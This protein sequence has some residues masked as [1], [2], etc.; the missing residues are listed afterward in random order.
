M[1]TRDTRVIGNP[2]IAGGG[3]RLGAPGDVAQA[4]PTEAMI[5]HQFGFDQGYADGL[6]QAGAACEARWKEIQARWHE[7]ADRHLQAAMADVAAHQ[8]TLAASLSRLDATL[9]DDRV[10]A[11]GVAVELAMHAL[12][13]ILIRLPA[14]DLVR[15]V[16]ERASRASMES[17]THLRVPE[18]D[19]TS[20]GDLP[21]SLLTVVDPTLAPG[22]YVLS[23][24]RGELDIGLPTRLRAI[25]DA[26]LLAL[27]ERAHGEPR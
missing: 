3:R 2:V 21:A 23:F 19:A 7:E 10:W 14:A 9:A 26:F 17:P 1:T 13:T 20:V 25:T 6:R 27:A 12:A 22:D 18:A 16:V 15:D 4:P 24:S 8:A 11:E 5:D